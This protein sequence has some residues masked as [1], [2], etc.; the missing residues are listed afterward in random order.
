MIAHIWLHVYD[1]TYV[2]IICIICAHTYDF[3]Y[4]FIRYTICA[5][6]RLHLYDII[7]SYV[8][9]TYDH[10]VC[11]H[12]WSYVCIHMIICVTGIWIHIYVYPLRIIYRF[13]LWCG[14]EIIVVD[15]VITEVNKRRCARYVAGVC[16]L[17]LEFAEDMLHDVKNVLKSP[18]VDM[19]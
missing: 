15:D 16:N 7:Q 14:W 10:T 17:R 9:Q 5:H 4:M 12:I 6:I 18:F 13:P 8:W 11:S 2:I 3:T 19:Y 1:Y